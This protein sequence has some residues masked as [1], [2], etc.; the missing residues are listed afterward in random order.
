MGGM[1]I[2]KKQMTFDLTD[3]FMHEEILGESWTGLKNANMFSHPLTL[4]FKVSTPLS[5]ENP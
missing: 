1:K 4:M 2:E 5:E 3:N